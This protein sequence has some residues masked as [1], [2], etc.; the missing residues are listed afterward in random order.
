MSNSFISTLEKDFMA[1]GLWFALICAIA[2]ILYG[3]FAIGWILAHAK[4][5]EKCWQLLRQSNKGHCLP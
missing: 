1:I 4:G 3:I 5:N 2:A